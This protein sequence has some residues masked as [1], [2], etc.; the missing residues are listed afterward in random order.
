L[1]KRCHP[2]NYSYVLVTGVHSCNSLSTIRFTKHKLRCK[3][4]VPNA[5]IDFSTYLLF[6]LLCEH[7]INCQHQQG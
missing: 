6:T 3:L 7:S 4:L 1:K 2:F 5:L